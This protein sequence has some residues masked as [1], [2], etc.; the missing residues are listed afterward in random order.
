M[1]TEGACQPDATI[2]IGKTYMNI[3]KNKLFQI[4]FVPLATIEKSLYTENDPKG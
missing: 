3:L 4:S 2:I 1:L